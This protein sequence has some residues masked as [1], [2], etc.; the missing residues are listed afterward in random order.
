MQMNL[1]SYLVVRSIGMEFV[2]ESTNGKPINI[3]LFNFLLDFCIGI[4]E[5]FLFGDLR[6]VNRSNIFHY[7]EIYDS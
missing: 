2:T 5:M 1:I 4:F 6:G 7:F 3:L